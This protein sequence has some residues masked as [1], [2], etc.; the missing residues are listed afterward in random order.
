MVIFSCSA[1]NSSSAG[2]GAKLYDSDLPP[3]TAPDPA[4][5][6]AA[7]APA[8]SAAEAASPPAAAA[9]AI[10]PAGSKEREVGRRKKKKALR[11]GED[12]LTLQRMCVCVCK[13]VWCVYVSVAA[14]MASLR[15]AE[16]HAAA[17]GCERKRRRRD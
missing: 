5:A 11:D 2:V 14:L 3:P 16:V 6:A 17:K 13:C 8:G 12:A 1:R 10:A 9:A 4:A 15:G 7:G